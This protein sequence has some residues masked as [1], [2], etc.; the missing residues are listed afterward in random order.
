MIR[1]DGFG[2]PTT[3]W[4]FHV[5]GAAVIVI[6]IAV[7]AL[8]VLPG[9]LNAVAAGVWIA[10]HPWLRTRWYRTGYAD[11]YIDGRSEPRSPAPRRRQSQ[12]PDRRG[13]LRMLRGAPGIADDSGPR[14]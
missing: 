10:A 4:P 12:R 3:D 1:S 5:I 14:R 13:R 2:A 7:I 8:G 6:G 11:G 9:G